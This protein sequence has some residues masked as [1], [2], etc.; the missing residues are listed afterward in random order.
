M[1][2]L[3]LA[4]FVMVTTLFFPITAC[5]Q[6]KAPTTSSHY[7]KAEVTWIVSEGEKKVLDKTVP[8]QTVKVKLLDG[9]NKNKE[10]T[11]EQGTQTTMTRDQRVN[12][13]DTVI[14]MQLVTD[15]KSNYFITDTYRLPSLIIL[16]LLFFVLVIVLSRLKGLG[17]IIGLV[18]SILIISQFIVPAILA[19]QDPLLVSALGA[20]V[21]IC[22]TIYLAHGF[23][24]KTTLALASTLI[25]LVV[26]CIL[27][28]VFVN[29]AHITGLG[30]DDAY[31]LQFGPTGSINVKGLL[32]GGII[33]GAIGVLDDVTTGLTAA[34]FELKSVHPAAKL[35]HYL[36]SG[37]NIGNEHIASL[38]NTLVLAYAGAS[39]PLFLFLVI[40]P[41][42]QPLWMVINNEFIAEEIVRTLAGSFG[43]VL[44][45]PITV[46]ITAFYISRYER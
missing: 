4:F 9:P 41:S 11:V 13:G 17:S 27:S 29:V 37:M 24:L 16:T 32:L 45:V 15:N 33:I 40:N 28:V 8:Y 43:L 6:D 39:L 3:F 18:V 12:V 2:K 38:V 7:Y 19:G 34:L 36:K 14:V 31:L 25:T 30:N 21:I 20:S 22:I 42:H 5:A 35:H 26:V 10:V 1:N 44:A 46:L 23:S